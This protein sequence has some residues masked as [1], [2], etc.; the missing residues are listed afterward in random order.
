ML[1]DLLKEYIKPVPESW[2]VGAV[3]GKDQPRWAL[4]GLR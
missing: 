3:K 2:E 1:T 4:I